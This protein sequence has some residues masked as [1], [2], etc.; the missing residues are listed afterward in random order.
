MIG[1]SG[2][3]ARWGD[4]LVLTAFVTLILLSRSAISPASVQTALM[5]APDSSSLAMM[6][7]SRSTSEPSVMRDV[8]KRKMWRFVCEAS[9]VNGMG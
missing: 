5:S 1:Q 2:R 7:S 9:E 6:Y 8:C 4:G 3:D